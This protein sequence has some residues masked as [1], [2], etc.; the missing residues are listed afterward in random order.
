MN[1]DFKSGG[2]GSPEDAFQRVDMISR[3]MVDDVSLE[4]PIAFAA[5]VTALSAIV[6]ALSAL[7]DSVPRIGALV[8][9]ATANHPYLQ[10]GALL[11]ACGWLIYAWRAYRQMANAR[12]HL[13]HAHLV[14]L[15]LDSRDRESIEK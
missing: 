2:P 7:A 9:W 6:T 11:L 1:Y 13:I 15:W 14:D 5:L 12:N 4:R 8:R 10:A 3:A